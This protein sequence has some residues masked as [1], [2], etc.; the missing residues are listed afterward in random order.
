MIRGVTLLDLREAI[1]IAIA[2]MAPV[3]GGL[4]LRSILRDLWRLG[5]TYLTWHMIAAIGWLLICIGET[6][7]SFFI[8][9]I[10]HFERPGTYGSQIFPL[11]VSLACLV[12]GF[13]LCIKAFTPDGW[14]RHSIWL[15]TL[16]AVL[17]G[18]VLNWTLIA[19]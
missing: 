9:D 15:P 16:A 12:F 2:I 10:L 8:W 13:M 6:L 19:S 11:M 4:Y 7:R 3:A 5:R 17:V 18:M 1:N 14:H